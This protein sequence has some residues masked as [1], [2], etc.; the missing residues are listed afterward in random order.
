MLV[1]IVVAAAIGFSLFV[2]SEQR[3]VQNQRAANQM[4]NLEGLRIVGL[5]LDLS[6][7]NTTGST[8]T[9]QLASLDINNMTLTGIDV[10]GV[11]ATFY[12][13]LL[14]GG[15]VGNGPNQCFVLSSGNLNCSKLI[16][17]GFS[18]TTMVFQFSQFYLRTFNLSDSETIQI[19]VFTS[20]GNEFVASFV[21][22]DAIV[23][24]AFSGTWPILDGA[25]SY[26]PSGGTG[27][28]TTINHWDWI[29]TNE[30]D[31]HDPDNGVY[32][33]QEA[34]LHDAFNASDIYN[35][36]LTVTNSFGLQGYAV[37]MYKA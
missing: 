28:N 29:V 24:I 4:K 32:Y 6:S 35:V 21:P 2:A 30:N 14:P 34:E 5:S 16:L 22:P 15:I 9:V 18:Q 13:L 12:G 37:E 31:S 23:G 11:P 17:R 25:G 1:L 26:Q 36:T 8:L 27:V 19:D 7:N 33:G 3:I 10:N 20:L